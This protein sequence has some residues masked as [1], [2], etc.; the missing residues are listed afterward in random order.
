ML[1]AAILSL[2]A[3]CRVRLSCNA[4]GT[5]SSLKLICTPRALHKHHA[6]GPL[7]RYSLATC[8]QVAYET[9]AAGDVLRQ[10]TFL[11]HPWLVCEVTT[12][13]RLLLNGREAFLPSLQEHREQ[14]AQARARQQALQQLEQQQD[15]QQQQQQQQGLQAGELVAAGALAGAGVGAGA[16]LGVQLVVLAGLGAGWPLFEVTIGELPQ[17]HWTV[18]KD[19]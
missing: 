2:D 15:Q 3:L 16:G 14:V 7:F 9:I 13:T 8:L 19:F 1:L 10:Q 18:S 4:A 5:A 12:G 11:T 6:A 17:L